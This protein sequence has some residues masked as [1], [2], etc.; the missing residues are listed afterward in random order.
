MRSSPGA[1]KL[2]RAKIV[3][4]F[5]GIG[6]LAGCSSSNPLDSPDTVKGPITVSTPGSNSTSEPRGKGTDNLMAACAVP[7]SESGF[8]KK[9][10]F[11]NGLACVMADF[12][13]PR[14][15]PPSDAMLNRVVL[16]FPDPDN[17]EF[18]TTLVYTV[19]DGLNTCAWTQTWL[20]SQSSGNESLER[21]SL[22][23]LTNITPY[24]PEKVRNFPAASTTQ[25]VT[26]ARVAMAGRAALGDPSLIQ[27]YVD[28]NCQGL[29]WTDGD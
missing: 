21:E 12:Q 27:Q 13:W 26:D 19:L 11:R 29:D 10:D 4:L 1:N 25:S 14:G 16:N 18:E 6:I 5:A 22:D 23:Y 20:E 8:L 17:A 7:E 24:L 2:L 28:G 15:K 9:D 3:F